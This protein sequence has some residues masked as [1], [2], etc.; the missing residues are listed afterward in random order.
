[1]S[2]LKGVS[3]LRGASILAAAATLGLLAAASALAACQAVEEVLLSPTPAAETPTPAGTAIPEPTAAPTPQASVPPQSTLTAVAGCPTVTEP[4]ITMALTGPA[5]TSP[6]QRV[7][8]R[9][10]YELIG[11]NDITI[12]ID[13]TE[14][15]SYLSA[16]RVSGAAAAEPEAAAFV[17]GRV[18]QLAWDVQKGVGALEYTLS[19][20]PDAAFD[21]VFTRAWLTGTCPPPPA[22]TATTVTRS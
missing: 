15:A 14:G 1:M 3:H 18:A 17:D 13:W 21:T 4:V 10:T 6:G 22:Y 19:I 8:Y 11:L 12:R 16:G 2:A 5:Q 20:P 9:L 7:T